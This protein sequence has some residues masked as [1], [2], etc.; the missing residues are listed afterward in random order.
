M[1]PQT[2]SECK[3][4][5][6]PVLFAVIT[7]RNTKSFFELSRKF[8][9]R[10]VAQ[11]FRNFLQR[12]ITVMQQRNCFFHLTTDTVSP[13]CHSDTR[14]KKF[15]EIFIANRMSA[16]E[17]LQRKW[18]SEVS[19]QFQT[20]KLH[21][22]TIFFSGFGAYSLNIRAIIFFKTES[23]LQE[24]K[25]LHELNHAILKQFNAANLEFAYP[26]QTLYFSDQNNTKWP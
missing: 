5:I 23:F 12:Q 16:A 8:I 7:G 13:G 24:E 6:S 18:F 14:S 25:F 17:F 4:H 22:I 3:Q 21:Q 10:M 26:T 2:N 1:F 11:Q 20:G 9:R 15:A 19:A